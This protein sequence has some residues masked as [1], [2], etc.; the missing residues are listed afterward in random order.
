MASELKGALDQFEAKI[1]ESLVGDPKAL[2]ANKRRFK[3]EMEALELS[4]TAIRLEKA[5]ERGEATLDM[6]IELIQ[7][8]ATAKK[9]ALQAEL[10]QMDET[11]SGL[12]GA[13]HTREEKQKLGFHAVL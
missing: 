11:K 3:T 4:I 8:R 10:E 9:N 7:E 2:E 5:R 13:W 12:F 6:E 1:N